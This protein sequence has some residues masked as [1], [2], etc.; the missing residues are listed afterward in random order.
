[1]LSRVSLTALSAMIVLVGCSQEAALEDAEGSAGVGG[2]QTDTALG[3][4]DEGSDEG[5][6]DPGP[7]RTEKEMYGYQY[8]IMP[9]PPPLGPNGET[10]TFDS[11]STSAHGF[12]GAVTFSALPIPETWDSPTHPVRMQ[13]A[14][15]LSYDL[16]MVE[17]GGVAAIDT[18]D[19]S[20]IMQRPIGMADFLRAPAESPDTDIPAEPGTLV[21]VFEVIKPG[22]PDEV[23]DAPGCATVRYIAVTAPSDEDYLTLASFSPGPWPPA[24]SARNCGIFNYA[25]AQPSP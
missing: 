11:D 2:A 5:E 25:P 14:N 9:Y 1:M 19:W 3:N 7:P 4:P 18:I 13:G 17:D 23:S 24:D 8:E 6:A 21:F 20:E 12:T 10:R 22:A 15:G 16:R